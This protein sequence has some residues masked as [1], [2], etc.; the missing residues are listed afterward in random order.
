MK[1]ELVSA[2]NPDNIAAKV[3]VDPKVKKHPRRHTAPSQNALGA[4]TTPPAAVL[5]LTAAVVAVRPLSL[6]EAPT[7]SPAKQQRRAQLSPP[8]PPTYISTCQTI[9]RGTL[10]HD[11]DP[12][13]HHASPLRRD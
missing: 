13:Y 2:Q 8:T 6:M 11:L 10:G 3:L 9:L 4:L 7:Q 1:A 5:S 12:S